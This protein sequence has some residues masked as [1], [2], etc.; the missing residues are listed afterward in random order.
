MKFLLVGFL[1]I[2]VSCDSKNSKNS[3]QFDYVRAANCNAGVSDLP[4]IINGQVV[5]EKS[6]LGQSSVVVMQAAWTE[7]GALVNQALCTGILID[8]NI[9][10]TAAH[11]ADFLYT[12]SDVATKIEVSFRARPE[13]DPEGSRIEQMKVERAII[14]PSWIQAALKRKIGQPSFSGKYFPDAATPM[15]QLHGDIALLKL[16]KPAP[17]YKKPALLPEKFMSLYD[18]S[19]YGAGFGTTTKYSAADDSERALRYTKLHP[20]K[21]SGL[22][23]NLLQVEDGKAPLLEDQLLTLVKNDKHNSAGQE[24]LMFD[25]TKGS[26]V[27]SGD[28]GGP[29]VAVKK[30]EIVVLGIA[31]AVYAVGS[32][33][34]CQHVAMHSS[35]WFYRKWIQESLAMLKGSSALPSKKADAK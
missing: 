20:L 26:G 12:M 23:V 31:S 15:M 1:L 25:Q 6:L 19:V 28:S 24:L 34:M 35:T 2:L 21:K 3:N 14:H 18:Q 33:E 22:A 30:R 11:C 9:V 29:A 13:C 16:E 4:G 27:C 10:L 5:R 8:S 7:S 17:E 32:R